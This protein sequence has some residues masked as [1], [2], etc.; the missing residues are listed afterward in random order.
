MG[1]KSRSFSDLNTQDVY[2]DEEHET[3]NEEDSDVR[4]H[5]VRRYHERVTALAG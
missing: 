5:Q 3:N 2:G 4:T 1:E